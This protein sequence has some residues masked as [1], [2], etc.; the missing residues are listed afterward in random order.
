MAS[1]RTSSNPKMKQAGEEGSAITPTAEVAVV[2][3][4]QSVADLDEFSQLESEFAESAT[5]ATG[6]SAN[7]Q[8]DA[9]NLTVRCPKCSKLLN[10]QGACTNCK[11]GHEKQR[12][13]KE[14]PVK[15][16]EVKTAGFS[17]WVEKRL[18]GGVTIKKMVIALY[19]FSCVMAFVGLLMAFGLGGTWAILWVFAMAPFAFVMIYT[20]LI[21]IRCATTSNN[22][23][24]W[25]QDLLWNLL[26]QFCRSNNWGRQPD[27]VAKDLDANT[28]DHQIAV[29][30]RLGK[31]QVL[32]LEGTQLSDDG[33][34]RL[35]EYSNIQCLVVRNTKV[36]LEGVLRYQQQFRHV[37][38]WY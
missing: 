23:L 35:Y 38:V 4:Q 34:K 16:M 2:E 14:V 3:N 26:L 8:F 22:K 15:H 18:S 29:L 31:L 24:Q 37:W 11:Y 9:F 27:L 13:P 5:M 30:P 33:L 6:T 7:L 21:W 20:T 10:K 12:M 25:W 32:D 19:V 17:L 1:T 36:T 28:F